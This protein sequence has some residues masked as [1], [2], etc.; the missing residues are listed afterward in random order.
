MIGLLAALTRPNAA[1]V[2]VLPTLVGVAAGAFTLAQLV[3]A[4]GAGS[5][6]GRPGRAR[7]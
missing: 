2:D 6:R 4:A 7:R 1:A 3:R 5:R